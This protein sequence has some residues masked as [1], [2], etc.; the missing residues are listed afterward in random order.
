M[1]L[2]KVHYLLL[3]VSCLGL[4]SCNNDDEI[5]EEDKLKDKYL[6]VTDEYD[7][8]EYAASF[9]NGVNEYVAFFKTDEEDNVSSID[10]LY[11]G[12]NSLVAVSLNEDGLVESVCG[13]SLTIVFSNYSGNNVDIAFVY[14]DE[15]AVVNDY[16]TE[17]D[18]D[19]IASKSFSNSR[20]WYDSVEKFAKPLYYVTEELDIAISFGTGVGN[21]AKAGIKGE[22]EKNLKRILSEWGQDLVI[23]YVE[24]YDDIWSYKV[25]N[26]N[27]VEF[28]FDAFAVVA[29]FLN[30]GAMI[31]NYS[32]YVDFF[33]AIFLWSAQVYD[34]LSKELASGALLRITINSYESTLPPEHNEGN[35]TFSMS[36]NVTYNKIGQ[37]V[38][39]WGVALFKGNELI[40][41]YPVANISEKTQ[42]IDFSFDIAKKQFNLDYDD[43]I[44][45][46]K[47]E[48]YLKAYEINNQNP[49]V[50]IFGR[51]KMV[52]DLVYNQKPSITM[53]DLKVGET[54]SINEGYWTKLT[55]YTY[56][57]VLTGSLF[58]NDSYL[59]YAGNW[60]NTG[61]GDSI[62]LWDGKY[63]SNEN[64]RVL[65]APT[66]QD[67]YIYFVS[68]VNGKLIKSLN[69]LYFYV[70]QDII[71]ISLVEGEAESRTRSFNDNGVMGEGIIRFSPI[72]IVNE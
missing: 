37:N 27:I 44:A 63:Q 54:V 22:V 31:L 69:H 1:K 35:V 29:S 13:D 46:P 65:Y 4:F 52:L 20:A 57:W 32:S 17:F 6:W 42:F 60:V 9:I 68:T 58:M 67:M 3:L 56:K 64:T 50:P 18:W 62:T 11:N 2:F 51:N 61:K 59:Y 23:E 49:G 5:K 26:V 33:Y 14:K 72:R 38:E 15:I 70:N 43:Y 40:G 36:T 24:T 19:D 53:Y 16:A 30:P 41:K 7:E 28:D 25:A 34:G 47:D 66:T 45:T 48:W 21:L 8:T 12:G 10:Y 71:N 55:Y 39:E